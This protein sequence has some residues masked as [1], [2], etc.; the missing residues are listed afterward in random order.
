MKLS[1]RVQFDTVQKDTRIVY[2]VIISPAPANANAI[3][4]EITPLWD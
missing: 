3:C 4:I 2:T 1:N